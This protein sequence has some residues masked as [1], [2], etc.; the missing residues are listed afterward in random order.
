MNDFEHDDELRDALR[1]AHPTRNEG[2]PT[3]AANRARMAR[4]RTR[5]RAAIGSLAAASFFAVGAAVFA[6]NSTNDTNVVD[7]VAPP[8]TL[9]RVSSTAPGEQPTSTT[10]PSATSSSTSSSTSTTR[11]GPDPTTGAPLPT[12][13]STTPTAPTTTAAAIRTTHTSNGGT[14]TVT[15]T[16]TAI[17]IEQVT[18]VAG[19]T[20][21]VNKNDRDDVEIEWRRSNPDG[22]SKIR[23][24][25]V[26]GEL[27]EEIE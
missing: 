6:V 16:A 24:R 27:R 13:P 25:L 3:L 26:A 20:P 15:H 19:W 10:A 12:Q 22:Q 9:T 23:L 5:R 8:S 4:A 7:V 14:L 17:T 2:R 18:D 1:R 11:G 21:T